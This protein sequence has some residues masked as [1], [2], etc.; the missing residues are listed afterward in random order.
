MT[1][2]KILQLSKEH[3]DAEYSKS[4]EELMKTKRRVQVKHIMTQFIPETADMLQNI[5]YISPTYGTSSHLC[6][7]GCGELSVTPLSKLFTHPALDFSNGQTIGEVELRV[8]GGNDWSATIEHDKTLTMTP[9]I[10]NNGCP[11][12]AHYVITRGI[13]NILDR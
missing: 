2:D 4:F 6:L 11:N 3:W 10:L 12:K 13:A 8:Y 7:C 1:T 5:I 9:S